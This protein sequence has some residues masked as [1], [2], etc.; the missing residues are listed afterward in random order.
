MRE[1]SRLIPIIPVIAKSDTMTRDETLE[2]RR[3]VAAQLSTDSKIRL[4]PWTVKTADGVVGRDETLADD[5]EMP[6]FTIIAAKNFEYREY[7]WGTCRL[8]DRQHSDF[9][10][11][12]RLVLGRHLLSLKQEALD[13]F[14]TW[15]KQKEGRWM[16]TLL[17]T[18]LPSSI[19]F[20]K[21]ILDLF[22]RYRASAIWFLVGII[23]VT[24]I[25]QNRSLSMEN[26]AVQTQIEQLGRNNTELMVEML[27]W[28]EEAQ[29]VSQTCKSK[30]ANLTRNSES[31][32]SSCRAELVELQHSLKQVMAENKKLEEERAEIHNRNSCI[33]CFVSLLCIGSGLIF[34][35][36]MT[37]RHV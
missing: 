9:T 35:D 2:F 29:K 26:R 32:I 22:P 25:L 17:F 31:Q 4:Y 14:S 1:V 10:L 13:T 7:A 15:K 8:D 30:A 16:P 19:A 5:A 23:L 11:L 27:K 33:L 6:P 18:V 12:R 21:V 28:K 36:Q 3:L 34:F 37:S 24:S 20:R